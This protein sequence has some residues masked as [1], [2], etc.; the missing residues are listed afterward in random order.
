[1][2]DNSPPSVRSDAA[3]ALLERS[4]TMPRRTAF[5]FKGERWSYRHLADESERV[6]AAM[7]ARG[8]QP[9]D[10]VALH[11]SN[12]PELI[13][14]YYGCFLMGATA[15]PLNIR[16]K[17]AELHPLLERLRPALY[18]G[19]EQVYANVSGVAP[20]V[21][22]A[23]ARFLA[24]PSPH[25]GTQ[26][27]ASLLASAETYP[28]MGPATPDPATPAVLLPTSGTTGAPKLVI[29]TPATLSAIAAS[30]AHLGINRNRKVLLALP[31]VHGAGFTLFIACI[32]LGAQ[33]TLLERFEADAV[34]DA[35]EAHRCDWMLG[36]PFMFAEMLKRQRDCP[37]NV[38][39]LA[40]CISAGDVCPSE[41]EAQ[42]PAAF[43]VDLRSVL[44]SCEIAWSLTYGRRSG[45]VSRIPSR[46]E[47]RLVDD[48]GAEVPNGQPGELMV[49]SASVTPGYWA[50]PGR[51]E[52]PL[53]DGWRR[54][55]DL[56]QWEGRD[57]LRFVAR[58]K[59]LIIR[60]G[61]NIVPA[62]VEEALR[63]DPA[64]EDALVVGVPDPELGERVAAL[65]EL[66]PGSD[67]ADQA[68]N[69]IQTEAAKRLADYKL[70]EHLKVVD[71]LP[72][73]AMGKL[74]RSAAREILLNDNPP[75]SKGQCR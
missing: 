36:L 5:V 55:G 20:D 53:Q 13:T 22:L 69:D 61:S 11:T 14:A 63:A 17:A 15:V 40:H 10:R 8:V 39:S 2:T 49:R 38:S 23:E 45:P 37:R 30:F 72:R 58:K 70:P 56:M 12:V 6:A 19:Q 67:G 75:A 26:P 21:L 35:I 52:E 46:T 60:S 73:N 1:M 7:R 24:D 4:R 43:G 74:D 64:V 68:P 47:A 31:M 28:R 42:F 66:T 33:V 50:G 51:I 32:H 48:D 34:L 27:W 29:H 57:S 3:A 41:L 54:S 16:L 9:G 25:D 71:A 59:E 62:E 65:L 44:A 18:L